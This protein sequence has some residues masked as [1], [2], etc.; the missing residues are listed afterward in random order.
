MPPSDIE[1]ITKQLGLIKWLLGCVISFAL[2]GASGAWAVASELNSL[3]SRD[4][5]IETN[6]A[7]VDKFGTQYGRDTLES[8]RQ[9]EY[10]VREDLTTIKVKLGIS[11]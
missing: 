7:A 5:K 2:A 11:K 3:H 4:T 1:R 9:F 6:L 8:R 10:Q